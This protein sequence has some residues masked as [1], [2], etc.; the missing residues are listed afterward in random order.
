MPGVRVRISM[1][2]ETRMATVAAMRMPVAAN[3]AALGSSTF[4]KIEVA[5]GAVGAHAC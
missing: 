2:T 3:G 1:P 5:R 4:R